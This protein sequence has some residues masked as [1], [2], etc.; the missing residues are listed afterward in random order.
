LIDSAHPIP[1]FE[2]FEL[3]G[4]FDSISL[5]RRFLALSAALDLDDEQA[6]LSPFRKFISASRERTNVKTQRETR[7]RWFIKAL[8]GARGV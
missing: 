7:I 8:T 5:E 4:D 1:S 6:L 3:E 2:P